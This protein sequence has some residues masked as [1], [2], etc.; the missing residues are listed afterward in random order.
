MRRSGTAL[1]RCGLDLGLHLPVSARRGQ[2]KWHRVGAERHHGDRDGGRVQQTP[3]QS[4]QRRDRICEGMRTGHHAGRHHPLPGEG[5]SGR[6]GP[7][8][9][10]K[11]PQSVV[12]SRNTEIEHV[13][14]V[15]QI[16]KGL[17]QS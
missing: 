10:T 6:P 1:S 13:H 7:V 8:Q 17:P 4:K 3:S 16:S 11:Q 5:L 9:E 12:N 15:G 2:C 14:G